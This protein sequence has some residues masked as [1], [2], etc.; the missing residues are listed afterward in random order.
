MRINKLDFDDY[1]DQY[2]ALLSDQVSFFNRDHSYFAKYK[3]ELTREVINRIPERIMDYGCGIGRS[4]PILH[5][6][7]PTAELFGCDISEKSLDYARKKYPY[8]RF[9][10]ISELQPVWNT[11]DL[12]FVAGLFHHVPPSEHSNV[13]SI[14]NRLLNNN[15]YVVIFEH[16][17]LNPLTLK[18]VNSCP[19]DKD[20]VLLNHRDLK[21]L[22]NRSDLNLYYDGYILFFPWFFRWLRPLE[23][24]LRYVPFG[25]QHV[26]CAVR[27]P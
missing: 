1:V 16:N 21:S 23:R 24:F 4:I 12:V 3:V 13:M 19:Y 22:V 7:F 8:A 27:R 20:A 6:C 9:L 14:I 2:D 10:T 25:G 15:A 11:F 5:K 26:V 17:P 18:I